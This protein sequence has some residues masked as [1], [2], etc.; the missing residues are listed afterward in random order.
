MAAEQVIAQRTLASS[1]EALETLEEGDARA[2][3]EED[4]EALRTSLVSIE[5]RL[6][7]VQKARGRPS[8]VSVYW[9]GWSACGVCLAPVVVLRQSCLAPAAQRERCRLPRS[10]LSQPMLSCGQPV[11][12]R[13]YTHARMTC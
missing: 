13:V 8:C 5:A 7:E 6:H 9:A 3:L 10:A 2:R 1:E 4:I 12:L 11:F